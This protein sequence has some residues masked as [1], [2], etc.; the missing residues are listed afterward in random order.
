M[1]AS[2]GAGEKLICDDGWVAMSCRV[3]H[4]VR[5]PDPTNATRIQSDFMFVLSANVVNDHLFKASEARL[6]K[7]CVDS[8][9]SMSYFWDFI[10]SA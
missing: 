2:V 4:D 1:S 9:C 3:E 6:W 8:S 7:V 5:M 10:S